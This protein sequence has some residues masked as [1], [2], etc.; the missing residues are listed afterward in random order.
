MYII[1]YIKLP[2]LRSENKILWSFFFNYRR[3]VHVYR[4]MF[5]C[6]SVLVL[7]LCMRKFFGVTPMWGG[8]YIYLMLFDEICMRWTHCVNVRPAL[9][10]KRLLLWLFRA[11]LFYLL[12]HSGR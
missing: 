2:V 5:T 11:R 1:M 10:K 9:L 3:Q 4:I 12:L 8:I 6:R 7:Y